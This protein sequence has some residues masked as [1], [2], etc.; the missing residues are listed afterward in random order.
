MNQTISWTGFAAGFTAFVGAAS[1]MID[2]HTKWSDF[3]STPLGALHLFIL[4]GAFV[5]MIAGA[6]GVQLPRS[7]SMYGD[8]ITDKKLV[9]I[10]KETKDESH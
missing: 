1:E 5:L 4:G 8:R 10:N 3:T 9:E 6:L 7:N 2:E